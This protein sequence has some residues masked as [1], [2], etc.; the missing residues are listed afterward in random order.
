MYCVFVW[1]SVS[2]VKLKMLAVIGVR[3]QLLKKIHLLN[4]KSQQ[5]VFETIYTTID[6]KVIDLYYRLGTYMKIQVF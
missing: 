2:V 6:F 1:L 5:S 4:L 3:I